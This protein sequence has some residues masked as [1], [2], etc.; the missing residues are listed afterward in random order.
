MANA[1]QPMMLSTSLNCFIPSYLLYDFLYSNLQSYFFYFEL[2]TL[3]FE[4]YD[5]FT[6]YFFT[7]LLFYFF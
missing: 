3:N 6:F 7:F 4:L 5:Y 2:C 1:S